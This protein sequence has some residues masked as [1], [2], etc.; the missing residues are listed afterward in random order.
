MRPNCF[1]FKVGNVFGSA[2]AGWRLKRGLTQEELARK[3]D[4]PTV[5]VSHFE[6]GH[7]F[8]NAESLRRL[9]DAL[10]V[11]ADFLLGRVKEPTSEDLQAADPEIAVL[12]RRFQS[13]SEEAREQ[14]K[15]LF[16][17]VDAMDNRYRESLVALGPDSRRVED[18][19]GISRL[20]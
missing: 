10:G 11:S 8:P 9:A 6:T 16:E 2:F 5:S 20:Y 18:S 15:Q 3:A 13:M 7:R 19:K 12:F 4:V 14:V 1:N 17:T